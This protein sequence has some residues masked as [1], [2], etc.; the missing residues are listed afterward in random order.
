MSNL[1]NYDRMLE[2]RRENIQ[3]NV[4]NA[5]QAIDVLFYTGKKLTIRSIAAKAGVSINFLYAHAEIMDKIYY[6]QKIEPLDIAEKKIKLLLEE[7][8]RLTERIA[9][10]ATLVEQQLINNR[11]SV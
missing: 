9:K 5:L 2:V 7:N 3:M 11:G 6:Y 8:K 4:Q 10:Y 1:A